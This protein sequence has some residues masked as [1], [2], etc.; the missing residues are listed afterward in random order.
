MAPGIC[1]HCPPEQWQYT[2]MASGRTKRASSGP[3]SPELLRR[4][5]CGDAAHLGLPQPGPGRGAEPWP[6]RGS[7]RAGSRTAGGG[8]AR[9]AVTI[10]VKTA[11]EPNQIRSL[12]FPISKAGYL[13]FY[14]TPQGKGG[15]KR[16]FWHDIMGFAFPQE[17]RAV[18]L[19]QV[20]PEM[21]QWESQNAYGRIYCAV[22]SVTGPTGRTRAVRTV[23]IVRNGEDIA[24]FVTAYPEK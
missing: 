18:L 7:E 14:A 4:L 10:P 19:A 3:T 17:L 23:W 16:R 20:T 21:L 1:T 6:V 12:D 11:M 15:D 5:G 13:L 22:V 24:R 9:P 2:A 8:A